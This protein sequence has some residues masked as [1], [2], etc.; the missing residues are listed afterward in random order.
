[1]TIKSFILLFILDRLKAFTWLVFKIKIF[2][3]C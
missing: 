1:M 2:Y 3:E